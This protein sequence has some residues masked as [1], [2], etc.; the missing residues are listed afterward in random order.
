MG[1]VRQSSLNMK[2]SLALGICGLLALVTA[3][4]TKEKLLETTQCVGTL[5]PAGCCPY[6]NWFCCNGNKYCAN[7][8]SNCP[9]EYDAKMEK[10]VKMAAEKQCDCLLCPGG[11]CPECDWFCCPDNQYCAA[12]AADCP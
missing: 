10:L 11:C 8:A 9:F 5:C 2:L 12:T 3:Q 6:V 7:N 4:G 1:R